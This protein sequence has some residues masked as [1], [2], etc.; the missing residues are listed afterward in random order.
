MNPVEVQ[1]LVYVW[2]GDRKKKKKTES[3]ERLSWY[4][5][6]EDFFSMSSSAS[7]AHFSPRQSA[8][9]CQWIFRRCSKKSPALS[10]NQVPQKKK[11]MPWFPRRFSHVAMIGHGPPEKQVELQTKQERQLLDEAAW[12]MGIFQGKIIGISLVK[13]PWEY[14]ICGNIIMDLWMEISYYVDLDGVYP[15]ICRSGIGLIKTN[16]IWKSLTF[17]YG[18]VNKILTIRSNRG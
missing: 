2:L 1:Q 8:K 15:P 14:S 17:M 10:L 16:S 7:F 18:D 5:S 9:M 4:P 13:I 3:W 6:Q 11:M 12:T